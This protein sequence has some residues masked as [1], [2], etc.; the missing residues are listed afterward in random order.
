MTDYEIG[1]RI[2]DL[3]KAS[4]LKNQQVADIVGYACD[5][6][7][8]PFY[9]GKR[10]F[11]EDQLITLSKAF[12]VRLEYLQ[13][14]DDWKTETD[15]LSAVHQHKLE[16]FSA[17]LNYLKSIGLSLSP[18]LC[19]TGNK[20]ELFQSYYFLKDSA[21]APISFEDFP[22]S[23]NDYL[24]GLYFDRHLDNP[25]TFTQLFDCIVSGDIPDNLYVDDCEG[26]EIEKYAI[27]VE[28]L[29]E[30]LGNINPYDDSDMDEL[31]VPLKSNPR[32]GNEKI[33]SYYSCFDKREKTGSLKK[34][35]EMTKDDILEDDKSDTTG[36]L[37]EAYKTYIDD[38][39]RYGSLE[40]RYNANFNGKVVNGIDINRVCALFQQ[41]DAL[42]KVSLNTLLFSSII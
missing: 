4:G 34:I 14:K 6:Q 9:S 25:V 32:E 19:F 37:P 8:S 36:E 12:N 30:L 41:I 39:L 23:S 18:T 2:K 17:I 16:D 21:I 40:I 5:K 7:I 42:A 24:T 1:Q 28:L 20:Y 38:T 33:C 31:S 22:V 15:M 26:G 13:G 11:A 29:D 35:S 27:D 10:K 3:A